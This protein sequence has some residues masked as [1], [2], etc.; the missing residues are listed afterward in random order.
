MHCFKANSR[1]SSCLLRSSAGLLMSG[2]AI[3]TSRMWI[4]NGRW[5][6]LNNVIRNANKPRKKANSS[7]LFTES[8]SPSKIRSTSKVLP[9]IGVIL[10]ICTLLYKK[11]QLL[12]K[13]L[14]TQGLFHMWS[15]PHLL[16]LLLKLITLSGVRPKI[17]LIQIGVQEA[18]QAD[19][20]DLSPHDVPCLD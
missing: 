19:K 2:F 15:Q 9:A 11:M 10:I 8:P 20:P 16:V 1:V 17:H 12:S 13:S 4:F 6:E 7:V 5:N 18:A 14:S 3:T